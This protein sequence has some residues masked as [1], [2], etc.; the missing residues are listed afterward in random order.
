[1]LSLFLLISLYPD[2]SG[3]G[4]IM[5]REA[6]HSG[7]YIDYQSSKARQSSGDEVWTQSYDVATG[8]FPCSSNPISCHWKRSQLP[9]TTTTFER[10]SLGNELMSRLTQLVIVVEACNPEVAVTP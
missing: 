6:F 8:K 9:V 2:F 5:Y 7:T 1:M 4:C 3:D 10:Q